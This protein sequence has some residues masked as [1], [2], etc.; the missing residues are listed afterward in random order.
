MLKEILILKTS[1]LSGVESDFLVDGSV[2]ELHGYEYTAER[3]GAHRIT[4][5]LKCRECLDRRWTGREHVVFGGNRYFLDG[6]PSSSKDNSDH[7][8]SHSLTFMLELDR[9]LS[10]TMF[11]DAVSGADQDRPRSNTASFSF[12][13]TVREFSR[14]LSEVMDYA[15]LGVVS[16][17]ADEIPEGE[18]LLLSFDD[19]TVLEAVQ[20]A[21]GVFGVP[22]WYDLSGQRPCIVFGFVHNAITTPLKYGENSPLLKIERTNAGQKVVNRCTGYGSGDNIPYYYPNLSPAGDI[23]AVTNR[24]GL[25]VRIADPVRAA[26]IIGQPLTYSKEDSVITSVKG[27]FSVNAYNDTD[28]TVHTSLDNPILPGQRASAAEKKANGDDVFVY[29][30]KGNYINSKHGVD[31]SFYATAACVVR[32]RLFVIAAAGNSKYQWVL[33]S[34]GKAVS[35]GYKQEPDTTDLDIRI[36]AA[37]AYVFSANM[38]M[39]HGAHTWLQDTHGF[40]ANFEGLDVL[41]GGALFWKKGKDIVSLASCGLEIVSGTPQEGDTITVRNVV[42]GDGVRKYPICSRLM[43][44]IYRE[45]VARGRFYD[46]VNSREAFVRRYSALYPESTMLESIY[47]RIYGDGDG[48]VSFLNPI[49]RSTAAVEHIVTLEEIKPTITGMTNAAG[50]RMDAL[51]AVDFDTRDD[52]ST[53]ETDGSKYAHPN[54]FIRL[55][56][57]D[58]QDGFNIFDHALEGAEMQI[59]MTSGPCAG[60]TF[61]IRVAKDGRTNLVKVKG[62]GSLERDNKGNVVFDEYGQPAQND[63]RTT[64]VWLCLEKDTTTYGEMMP[65]RGKYEPQPGDTFVITGISLPDGYVFAAEKRLEAEIVRYMAENNA[66]TYN[67]SVGFSRVFTASDETVMP[68]LDENAT[69]LVEYDG[70]TYTMYVSQYVIRAREDSP[71][72][73]VSITVAEKVSDNTDA[74]RQAVSQAKSDMEKAVSGIDVTRLGLPYFL[75]KDIDDTARGNPAFL[76]GLRIGNYTPG[77]LGTGGALGVDSFGNSTAEVDF[78]NVRKKAV[79]NELEIQKTKSVGGQLIVSCASVEITSVTETEDAYRCFFRSE[80]GNGDAALNLFREGDLAM[81]RSF[82]AYSPTFWWRKVVSIGADY[83]DLSRTDCADG[84]GIPR[85]G[86]TAV[87]LGNVSDTSRQS[88]QVLSCYGQNA[89][90]FYIY[91]GI[92]GYSLEGCLHSGVETVDGKASLFVF[93]KG[94]IGDAE[95]KQYIES[96]G[97]NLVVTGIINA[98]GGVMSG[99]LAVNDAQNKIRAGFSGGDAGKT[100]E[101]GRMVMF[102]G[103]DNTKGTTDEQIAGSKTRMYEDGHLVTESAEVKG[104]LDAEILKFADVFCSEVRNLSYSTPEQGWN[105][106]SLI[107]QNDQLGRETPLSEYAPRFISE[108]AISDTESYFSYIITRD[109]AVV[110]EN[111][112]IVARYGIGCSAPT[113]AGGTSGYVIGPDGNLLYHK[114]GGPFS[115]HMK[116]VHAGGKAASGKNVRVGMEA[117]CSMGPNET[118]QNYAF[119]SKDGM[120]AGLRPKII[121]LTGGGQIGKDEGTSYGDNTLRDI[122]HTVIID[123]AG[124]LTLY[125]PQEPK[126]GQYYEIIQVTTA[127]LTIVGGKGTAPHRI[128]NIRQGMTDTSQW[129]ADRGT[130]RLYWSKEN[131]TWYLDYRTI[132]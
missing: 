62:D 60:C 34:D 103:A 110:A 120:F 28:K 98:L 40:A 93:G 102:G 81:A 117:N 75:R 37:G 49:E 17:V 129:A 107:G 78:L 33:Y 101:H 115:R 86:D 84:S 83:M 111:D 91:D 127:K 10:G 68:R 106:H 29:I 73:E 42:D 2:C 74:I 16:R 51:A 5:T 70:R 89:P 116:I 52:D 47:D 121:R 15:G 27:L 69:V 87:Q 63:T 38:E 132:V 99:L 9:V 100:D 57:L 19:R 31:V 66:E 41:G 130:W 6:T 8:Y 39:N 112:N 82:D 44:Y 72:P 108:I 114:V 124:E 79:F 11:L 59:S 94:Y 4:A 56:K 30:P 97:G 23:E 61:P 128:Y 13:G 36:P 45:T 35:R 76:N 55:P 119:M 90:S 54:F 131:D 26:R 92:S 113:P 64:E 1:G 20:D 109:K 18:S 126:Y 14:R 48:H 25:K 105:I 43:P 77:M 53:L 85:A 65:C 32:F 123:S 96:D 80:D 88:A 7:R 12:Y 67:F 3:M 22:Y 122:D 71:I 104:K 50:G 24:G 21:F 46:A 125:L 118:G 95:R 58:G